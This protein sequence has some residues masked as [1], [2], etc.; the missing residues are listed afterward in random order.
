MTPLLNET[1]QRMKDEILTDVRLG[2]VPVNVQSFA[3][4]HDYRDANAYGGF[5][6]DTV[7]DLLI[8]HFGGR[9]SDEAMPDGFV[10]FMNSAQGM[11]DAWLTTGG[12][13]TYHR[14]TADNTD[15]CVLYAELL[16]KHKQ[17]TI[18]ADKLL[19]NLDQNNR[20]DKAKLAALR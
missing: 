8:E 16:I 18:L 3:M 17:L 6:D 13:L 19:G 1:V 12:L 11:I 2:L 5:C 4:L 10:A 15:W 20:S 7:A 14:S 9:D